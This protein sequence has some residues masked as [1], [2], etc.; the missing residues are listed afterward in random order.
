[1]VQY[2]EVDVKDEILQQTVPRKILRRSEIFV[3]RLKRHSG[4]IQERLNFNRKE[5]LYSNSSCSFYIGSRV[6]RFLRW[7]CAY[8]VTYI[9]FN[10]FLGRKMWGRKSK[11]NYPVNFVINPPSEQECQL[12]VACNPNSISQS[13]TKG[14]SSRYDEFACCIFCLC[15]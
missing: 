2:V 14:V 6:L 11:M 8:S 1:M 12:S 4:D 15:C 3:C 9:F 7:K 10:F 13:F 5:D